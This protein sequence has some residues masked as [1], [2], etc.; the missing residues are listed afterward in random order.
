MQSQL[1]LVTL[2]DCNSSILVGPGPLFSVGAANQERGTITLPHV[3]CA[4]V[5]KAKERGVT[6]FPLRH[7][8]CS[9]SVKEGLSSTIL[10]LTASLAPH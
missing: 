3:L 2:R 9:K 1:E 5:P 10:T 8:I 7:H 6:A 4:A